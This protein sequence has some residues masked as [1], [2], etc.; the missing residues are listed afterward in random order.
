MNSLIVGCLA[1]TS[2]NFGV[3]RF[4]IKHHCMHNP[5]AANHSKGHGLNIATASPH[6]SANESMRQRIDGETGKAIYGQRVAMAGPVFANISE[7]KDLRGFSLRGQA[8]AQGQWQLYCL[9]HN[10]E[11][12]KNYGNLAEMDKKTA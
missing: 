8:K 11:K 12:W 3:K 5:G 10:I 4:P 7:Q 1:R 6:Q 9:I 2:E